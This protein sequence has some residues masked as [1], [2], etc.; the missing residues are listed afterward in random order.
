MKRHASFKAGLTLMWATIAASGIALVCDAREP[1]SDAGLAPPPGLAMWYDATVI[2][3]AREA[4]GLPAIAMGDRVEVWHDGSGNKRHVVNGDPE[5]QPTFGATDN[6][7]SLRFDGRTQTLSDGPRDAT[8][9]TWT[10][11]VV[12]APARV[13]GD[14]PGLICAHRRD[15]NDYQSGWNVDLGPEA[16]DALRQINVEGAGFSGAVNLLQGSRPLRSWRRVA[17]TARDASVELS[18]DGVPQDSRS[19][20]LADASLQYVEIGARYCGAFPGLRG[21]FAGEI[22]EILFFD[23]ALN[24]EELAD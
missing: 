23:R 24:A 18:L 16:T 14:F 19:R 6:R 21:Y 11:F 22:A 1:W 17:V 13:D 10:L 7:P 12:A 8:V 5:S 4:A 2:A 3:A 9:R 20:E 15:Q